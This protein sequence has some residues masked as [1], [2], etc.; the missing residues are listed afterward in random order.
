MTSVSTTQLTPLSF[1]ERSS[2]V[3][4][5]K[6]AIVHGETR[7]TYAEF[8]AS[9]MRLARALRASGVRSGDRVVYL[10]PNVPEMLVAHFGVPLA[11]GVLVAVNTRLLADEVRYILQ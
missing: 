9:A 7:V 4:A 8:G 5:D 10:M 6:P 2:R 1:L 11:G 3:W